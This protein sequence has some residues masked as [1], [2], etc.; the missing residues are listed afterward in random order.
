[1]RR[2]LA[3]FALAQHHVLI[4][5]RPI[6]AIAEQASS[7]YK[8]VSVTPTPVIVRLRGL[9]VTRREPMI[10]DREI[11]VGARGQNELNGL[12]ICNHD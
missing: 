12:N 1:M 4:R 9:T 7:A 11:T 6:H 2:K 3:S 5:S 10:C 8:D